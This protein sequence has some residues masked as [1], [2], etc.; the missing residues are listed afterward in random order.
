MIFKVYYQE[1]KSQSPQREKTKSLYMEAADAIN[2]RRILE[3]KTPYNIELVQELGE[4][5]L[6]YEKEHADFFL[7]EFE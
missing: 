6:A 3:E 7:T 5:H 4:N 2:A 1:Q